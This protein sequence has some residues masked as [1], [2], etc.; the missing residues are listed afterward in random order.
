[1]NYGETLVYWYLRLN[2]FFPLRDFVFHRSVAFGGVQ[3][4][5]CDLLAL[6]LPHVYEE[7]GGRPDDWDD[8][9][10]EWGIDLNSHTVGLIVQ[11]KTGANDNTPGDAFSEDRLI[12]AI[13][14]LGLVSHKSA[15]EVARE[16][17]SKATYEIHTTRPPCVIAKLFVGQEPKESEEWLNLSLHDVDE[18]IRRRIEK[19]KERKLAD[20]LRFPDELMQYL[21]WKEGS[22]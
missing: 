16:L 8:R 4:S 9:F 22:P 18:F 2:G 5:D 20:R 17:A 13:Q 6:R 21:A 7:V 19:Y 15:R 3:S 10:R 11:V 12:M 14:R 1:M